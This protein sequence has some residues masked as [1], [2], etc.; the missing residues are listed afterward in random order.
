MVTL[1]ELKGYLQIPETVTT[2]D[3]KLSMILYSV[4]ERVQKYCNRL[5]VQATTTERI[6]LI[7][8]FGFLSNTPIIS[9]SDVVDDDGYSYSA[10]IIDS[11]TGEISI[12]FLTNREYNFTY[13]GG[14][15]VENVPAD[16]KLAIM[17]W[18][19]FI[20]NN[21]AGIRKFNISGY[22]SESSISKAGMPVEVEAV[23]NAYKHTRL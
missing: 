14:V 12:D 16:I 20:Y 5:F 21:Q 11:T 23:L 7:G 19:E 15:P 17:Q 1:S 10:K 4:I 3:T 8:G 2:Y 22:S 13:E 9:I 6:K 18:S